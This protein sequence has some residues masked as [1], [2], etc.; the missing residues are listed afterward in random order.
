MLDNIPHIKSYW[1]MLGVKL[2]QAALHFGADDLDGTIVEE[3]I[4]HD[5]G[6]Q[7][8]QAMTIPQLEEMITRSGFNPVRRNSFFKPVIVEN[9]EA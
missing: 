5:A 8:D 3:K 4:G 6:A 2:A 1:V 7:S 9:Q